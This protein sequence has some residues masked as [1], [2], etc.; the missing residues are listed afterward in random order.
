MRGSRK[1]RS[2]TT[3][4]WCRPTKPESPWGCCT[5]LVALRLHRWPCVL[6]SSATAGF[7]LERK[8]C[9]PES[10]GTHELGFVLPVNSHWRTLGNNEVREFSD[11]RAARFDVHIHVQPSC[12]ERT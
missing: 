6:L 5:R 12:Q 7:A 2:R 3:R 10:L 4:S 11:G 1:Y 8:L 9:A